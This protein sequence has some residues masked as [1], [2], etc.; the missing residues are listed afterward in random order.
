[1]KN[2]YMVPEGDGYAPPINFED[3]GHA[4]EY[5]LQIEQPHFYEIS[6]ISPTEPVKLWHVAPSEKGKRYK[7]RPERW[8]DVVDRG[9]PVEH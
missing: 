3:R 5:C 1:M 7:L 6:P 4:A 2:F 8:A 9:C